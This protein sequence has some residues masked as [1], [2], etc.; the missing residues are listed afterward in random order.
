MKSYRMLFPP[1]LTIMLVASIFMTIK[2]N[3][4]RSSQYSEYI[5]L[6]REAVQYEIYVDAEKYYNEALNIEESLDIYHELA[7]MYIAA[8]EPGKAKDTGKRALDAFPYS[9]S[10]YA[11]CAGIYAEYKDYEYIYELYD[12]YK[13]RNLYDE[14]MEKIYADIEWLYEFGYEYTDVNCYAGGL[15]AV[16][17][18]KQWGYANEQGKRVI[19]NKYKYAGP[20]ISDIAPVQ[21]EQGEWYFI[22]KE[23]N[24]KKVLNKIEKVKA[25]GI[26]AD[27]IPVYDGEKWSYYNMDQKLICGSYDKAMTMANGYAAVCEGNSWYL[28][29]ESGN[30][31]SDSAYSSIV[32]D[33]KGIAYRGRYFAGTSGDY[34]MYDADGNDIG[35]HS[36]RDAKLFN[37]TSGYAAVKISSKWGFVDMDGNIVI[38][39]QYEDARSFSNGVAAVKKNDRWG[40]IDSNNN[41]VIEYK[42]NNVKDFNSSGNV[43]V[44]ECGLWQMLMLKRYQK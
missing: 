11:L 22:D 24:K 18:E 4:E 26:V 31:V 41:L 13:K 8:E 2:N 3:R 44:D 40:F 23:G 28:I 43:W 35:G 5:R 19:E 20:F 32:T 1:A 39:P 27:A 33:E 7:N 17:M 29:D 34:H 9:G 14:G 42:F 30:K 25:I 16:A 37:D 10:A 12:K 36:Y 15:C 6:A 21:T 38:E